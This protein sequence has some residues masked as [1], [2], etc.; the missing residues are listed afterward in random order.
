MMQPSLVAFDLDGT[1]IDSAGGI[2]RA[3]NLLLRDLDLAPL[4]LDEVRAGVGDGVAQLLQ[5]AYASQDH[6]SPDIADDVRR[7]IAHYSADPVAHTQLYPGVAETLRELQGRGLTLAVCTNKPLQISEVIIAKLGIA[8]CFSAVFGGDSR[9]YRKPD[10][11]ILQDLLQQFS[12]R[13][14]HAV[15][16]GD[17]EV[18]SATAQAAGVKFILVTFGYHR[19]GLDRIPRNHAVDRFSELSA[20]LAQLS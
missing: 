3:L 11:R 19:G 13:P 20:L 17:S 2:R 10:P 12:V 14:D 15:L 1:L 16:V 18:D 9:P 6:A 4:T 8:S 5:R 7:F